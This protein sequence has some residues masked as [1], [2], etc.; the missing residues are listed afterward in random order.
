MLH[1]LFSACKWRA[2]WLLHWW[3]CL[4]GSV[5]T[6]TANWVRENLAARL[7]PECD[8]TFFY[9][10]RGLAHFRGISLCGF[11]YT[12][13]WVPPSLGLVYRLV[14]PATHTSWAQAVTALQ[15]YTHNQGFNEENVAFTRF[16]PSK[17][18][19]K[20]GKLDERIWPLKKNLL[21]LVGMT[22]V[23]NNQNLGYIVAFSS[24]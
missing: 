3:I 10:S 22:R 13:K 23:M 24:T 21:K 9:M 18:G 7:M 19:L 5:R 8:A 16:W 6:F 4:A 12:G 2:A 1:V 14:P 20:H 11:S 17:L 15:Y